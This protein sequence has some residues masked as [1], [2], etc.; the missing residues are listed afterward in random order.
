MKKIL[1][2]ISLFVAVSCVQKEKEKQKETIMQIKVCDD[3]LING[4]IFNKLINQYFNHEELDE[5]KYFK[6][7]IR[8]HDDL[9]EIQI[10]PIIQKRDTLRGLPS[11]YMKYGEKDIFG[12]LSLYH[13]M[14]IDNRSLTV[15]KYRETLKKLPEYVNTVGK[16]YPI[17]HIYIKDNS[18]TIDSSLYIPKARHS[19]KFVAPKIPK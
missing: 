13:L 5:L 10:I 7:L 19:I 2:F 4:S 1:I 14:P 3:R 9:I 11:S 17:W 18:Y 8:D 12:L 6:L 16:K 15:M